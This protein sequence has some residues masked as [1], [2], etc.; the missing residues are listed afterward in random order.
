MAEEYTGN[1]PSNSILRRAK[2][3]PFYLRKS[4]QRDVEMRR[5]RRPSDLA[6]KELYFRIGEFASADLPSSPRIFPS[7]SV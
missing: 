3:P 2:S 7:S 4:T 5:A 1:L 6:E